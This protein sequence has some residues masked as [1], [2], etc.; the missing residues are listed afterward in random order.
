MD[1]ATTVTAT[2]VVMAGGVLA[3]GIVP[4][5]PGL[6]DFAGEIVHTGSWPADGVGLTGKSVG[7]IGTGSS[8]IQSTP[9][10]AEQAGHLSV[11][12]RTPQFA[13]PAWEP[14]DPARGDGGDQGRLPRAAPPRVG[15]R[16]RRPERAGAA[17]GDQR[18]R[19]GAR[20]VA[21]Q[22]VGSAAATA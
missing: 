6:E 11:F 22:D 12:Q 19:G 20:A 5:I 4:A 21:A 7:I 13:I 1:A 3:N 14:P 18:R 2:F 17:R 10:I 9:L 8:G 16:R 15:D